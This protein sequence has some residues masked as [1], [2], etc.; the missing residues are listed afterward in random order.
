MIRCRA[1]EAIEAILTIESICPTR[2]KEAEG[3]EKIKASV[4]SLT[5]VP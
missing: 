3:S 4:L 5:S 2:E 1:I